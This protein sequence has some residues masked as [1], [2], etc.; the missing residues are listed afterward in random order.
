MTARFSE[1]V[2]ARRLKG[3]GGVA[4]VG[5]KFADVAGNAALSIGA[6]GPRGGKKK[7]SPGGVGRAGSMYKPGSPG[8]VFKALH[9]AP[10]PR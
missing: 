1:G 6:P 8:R 9:N 4:G 5:G 10:K 7:L 2:L 3:S